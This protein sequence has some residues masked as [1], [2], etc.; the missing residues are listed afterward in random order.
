M[1]VSG[2]LIDTSFV[3]ALFNRQD[4]HHAKALAL[5][6]LVERSK[7]WVTEAV[8]IE[9]GDGMSRANRTVAEAFIQ[10]CYDAPETEVIPLD[11]GLIRRGLALY[12]DRPDKTWGLTDCLSF[13]AMREFGLTGALTADEHFVQAGFRALMREGT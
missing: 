12:R 13:V 11:T 1:K 9:I 4:Q 3:I 2:P 6:P 8:L 7:T 5:V 10:R